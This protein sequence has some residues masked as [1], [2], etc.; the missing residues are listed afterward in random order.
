MSVFYLGTHITSWLARTDIPLFVSHRR[1]SRLR[2][3]PRAA[4]RWMLDSGGFTEIS[5]YG[6]WRTPA[7]AYV[8]AVRRYADEIGGLDGAAIQD[9][10]C[11]PFIT[12]KTG[13]DVAAHQRRTVDSYLELMSLDSSLPWLPVLQ[14]WRLED[15]LRCLE[16][17]QRA[18][19]DL[20]QAWRVGL[21]SV[22]RRQATTE[23]ARIVAALAGEGLKLHG[24]GFKLQG[25]A[26]VADRLASSDSLAWSYDARRSPPL[27]GHT[28]LNCANCLEWATG[29]YQ[30]RVQPI[31]SRPGSRPVQLAFI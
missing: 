12:A 30:D 9:W 5:M 16:L 25:L 22:C 28:H 7:R 6:E 24:F 13:R 19:V 4:G 23:A 15:Y 14:G 18:G 10:M 26:L 27:P 29:W 31:I 21:G 20:R 8:A 11:E 17:Y 1:L 3:L 2:Q